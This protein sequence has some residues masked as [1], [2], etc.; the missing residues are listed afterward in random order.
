MRRE[1]IIDDSFLSSER[2]KQIKIPQG[3]D[4]IV[5]IV[6]EYELHISNNKLEVKERDIK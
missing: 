5:L 4:C 1:K 3:K 2:K 6:G